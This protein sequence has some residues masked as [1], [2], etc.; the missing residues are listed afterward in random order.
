MLSGEPTPLPV[1]FQPLPVG[2]GTTFLLTSGV[3]SLTSG[4][5]AADQ[6][7][8]LARCWSC[9]FLGGTALLVAAAWIYRR[10]RALIRS[11][12]TPGMG[13]VA[14]ITFAICE[15]GETE[16]GGGGEDTRWRRGRGGAGG[17]RGIDVGMGK[18][19][20]RRGGRGR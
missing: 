10:P 14:Q 2:S 9:R 17:G 13:D 16:G 20:W 12:L 5:M 6:R 11:G 3:C 7:S 1:F 8:L 4:A 18:A 19:K 15:R